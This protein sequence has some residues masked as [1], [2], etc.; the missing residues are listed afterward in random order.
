VNTQDNTS[1]ALPITGGRLEWTAPVDGKWV[2]RIV[3]H[4][5]RTPVT[6]AVNDSTRAKTTK[7]SMG[8]LLNP[9]AVRQFIDWTHEAYARHLGDEL[10]TTVLGFRGD[11]P[12][13][14]HVPYTTGILERFEQEKGY[15]VR[16]YLA[17]FVPP[18]RDQPPLKLTDEQR[19]ARADYW[20]VWSALF[21][22]HFF[23]QQA[24]WCA[25][26]SVEYITHLNNEH[27]MARL[28]RSTGDFFRPMRHVQ[29]PGVD[30]IWNQVWP[31]KNADFVRLPASAA[32]VYGRPRALS[33][34]FAA[35]NPA[36]DVAQARWAV[37]YQ[38]VRGINLFELMFYPSSAKSGT[39]QLRAYMGEPT[40]PALAAYIN[41]VSYLLAQGR[42]VARIAVYF[43]SASNW[44][45]DERADQS[46]MLIARQLLE[47]QRDFDF[48]D[49]QA[50]TEVLV[51]DSGRLK[52]PNGP[53]YRAVF[54]PS[55]AAISRATLQ[56]LEAFAQAGGRVVVIG[57]P[58][59]LGFDR[60]FREAAAP[61]ALAWALHEPTGEVTSSVLASLPASDVAYDQ[62]C[63]AIKYARRRLADADVYFFF[64]ESDEPQ[65][66]LVTLA[67]RG[68]AQ[69]W[70]GDT[71][72]IQTITSAV[73]QDG[74]LR[75]PL[76]LNGG[77]A[78]IIVLTPL[79]PTV[80]VR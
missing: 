32:H 34:S 53:S 25:A 46:A 49:E 52:G 67:G 59:A 17:A 57:E 26:H 30:S 77:E 3:D 66:R 15:D 33:E 1:R 39:A 65:A 70:D 31:G 60:S 19:R 61:G 55:G 64:N 72:R 7:N 37:N 73:A 8:D 42:P 20:D 54:V 29:I 71:G 68:R 69:F 24:Q 75:L 16:P 12:D 27:Q 13:F 51:L 79:A 74:V 6:R 43:P 11:E 45:G 48:I 10:G 58:P 50:L 62:P 63:P 41:R 5:F 44:L 47:A 35:Y 76:E 22:E 14:G 28:T 40:F 80:T 23:T 38:F 2:V 4:Q 56:R 18:G 78:R 36:P 9:A 21:A